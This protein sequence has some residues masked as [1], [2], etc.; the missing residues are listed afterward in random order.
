MV[1]TLELPSRHCAYVLFSKAGQMAIIPNS[2]SHG[3]SWVILQDIL[4]LSFV[5]MTSGTWKFPCLKYPRHEHDVVSFSIKRKMC[6]RVS[7]PHLCYV[8]F[9]A[10]LHLKVGSFS[11]FSITV[12]HPSIL[13]IQK[14]GRHLWNP[15]TFVNVFTCFHFHCY[16][17]DQALISN[18]G[19]G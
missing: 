6:T 18:I 8:Q 9:C 19:S 16:P 10:F 3:A 13:V 11:V 17:H 12:R 14:P 4:E 5:Y 7:L 1:T 2:V 15:P